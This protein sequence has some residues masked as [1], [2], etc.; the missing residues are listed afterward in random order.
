MAGPLGSLIAGTPNAAPTPVLQPQTAQPTAAPTAP[1]P[2]NTAAPAVGP[3]PAEEGVKNQ[4]LELLKR[5]EVQVGLTQFAINILSPNRT[6]GGP[7]AGL[8][9]AFGAGAQATGRASALQ[10]DINKEAGAESRAQQQLQQGER[11]LDIQAADVDVKRQ[12]LS[13]LRTQ[14]ADTHDIALR[15][16][17]ATLRGQDLNVATSVLAAK[18]KE[19][20]AL[21]TQLEFASDPNQIAQLSAQIQQIQQSMT[22][23][24]LRTTIAARA[25]AENKDPRKELMLH[26]FYDQSEID[27]ILRG[28]NKTQQPSTEVTPGSAVSPGVTGSQGS[29]TPAGTTRAPTPAP[30]FSGPI[31]GIPDALSQQ[32]QSFQEPIETTPGAS[33]GSIALRQTEATRQAR[34]LIS[35]LDPNTITADQIARIA[36]KPSLKQAL[37]SDSRF[38]QQDI[39]RLSRGDFSLPIDRELANFPAQIP[40]DL[41]SPQAQ[42]AKSHLASMAKNLISQLNEDTITE[43]QWAIVRNKFALLAALQA[44][45]RFGQEAID[46]LNAKYPLRQ[47]PNVSPLP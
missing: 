26:G 16:N 15:N 30:A 18:Q 22:S 37:M 21:M 2:T 35:Q 10:R 20:E 4:W 34:E 33:P 32:I 38:S 13:L 25:I 24:A 12:R 41:T 36:Q 46:R 11:G 14:I 42:V 47:P 3:N 39:E 23:I 6:G 27:A 43:S 5:P 44:D 29:V 8:A 28:L 1:A 19:V 31:P 40:T 45:P 9:N 17:K 7:I